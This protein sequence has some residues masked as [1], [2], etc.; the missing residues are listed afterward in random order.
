M[1]I[2]PFPSSRLVASGSPD[3]DHS[4]KDLCPIDTGIEPTWTDASGEGPEFEGSLKRR[5]A[6]DMTVSYTSSDLISEVTGEQ[7]FY[8]KSELREID[9]AQQPVYQLRFWKD[10]GRPLGKTLEGSI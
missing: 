4:R 7:V 5:Y 1:T 10:L 3:D 2:A 9:G 8:V 6:V